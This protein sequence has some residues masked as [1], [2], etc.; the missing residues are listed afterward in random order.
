MPNSSASKLDI[1]DLVSVNVNNY[2]GV[3]WLH[4]RRKEKVVSLSSKDFKRLLSKKRE[5]RELIHKHER[6]KKHK[7]YEDDSHRH[8]DRT[9]STDS[10]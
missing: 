10:E 1:N 5:I 4:I 8:E 6:E 2:K 3:V 9:D 7:K